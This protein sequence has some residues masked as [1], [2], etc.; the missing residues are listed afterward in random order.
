MKIALSTDHTGFEQLK[1]LREYLTQLGHTCLDF[2]PSQHDEQDDYPDFIRPAAE[3]VAHGEAD[4]GIIMGGSGQGEAMV[5][6]RLKGVRCAVYYGPATPEGAIEAEGTSSSDQYDIVRLSRKHN[7]AN[8]LSIGIRFVSSD[9][10]K[11]AVRIWLETPFSSAER[12]IRR[13]KKIDTTGA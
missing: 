8:M 6:N 9:T 7:D 3:T 12:H 4:F 10:L 13:I 5:A 11:E 2:G 1:Q